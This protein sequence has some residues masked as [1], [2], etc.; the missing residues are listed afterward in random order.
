MKFFRWSVKV[1]GVLAFGVVVVG[2][3]SL[4]LDSQT[5]RDSQYTSFE[6]VSADSEDKVVQ[7]II[8]K[9]E[10]TAA[11]EYWT[12]ERMRNAKPM[13]LGVEGAAS[14][15]TFSLAPNGPSE[16]IPGQPPMVKR[17]EGEALKFQPQLSYKYPWPYTRYET[18]VP[19]DIYPY[20]TIGKVFFIG[21]D[22]QDYTC[23]AAVVITNTR[24]AVWTAGH[25]VH[26]G[27]GGDWAARWAFVPAYRE[28]IAPL[29]IWVATELWAFTEWV[30][31]GNVRYDQGVAI[32]QDLDSW[33]IGDV[34]GTLGIAWNQP[35]NQHYNSFGYPDEDWRAPDK[36]FDGKHLITCQSWTATNGS[37]K[38]RGPQTQG[39]GCDL[40]GGSRGGPW[41]IRFGGDGGFLNSVNSYKPIGKNGLFS[42]PEEMYGPYF[43]GATGELWSAVTNR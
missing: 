42:K 18:F 31:K 35:R 27:P 40:T 22:G 10:Y 17:T 4:L 34:T 41:V 25:C 7:H 32:M 9:Q 15:G 29:G 21:S 38:G 1:V 8:S 30:V 36:P 3:G 24:R 28:G 2:C 33:R 43:D 11:L 16:E 14:R 12:V 20:S 13:L 19:Y 39:I 6:A 37:P 23:S 26:A 5:D